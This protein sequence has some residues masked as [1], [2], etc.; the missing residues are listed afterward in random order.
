MIKK[1]ENIGFFRFSI[2]I[3]SYV[4]ILVFQIEL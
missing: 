2:L 3:G 4:S 1:A